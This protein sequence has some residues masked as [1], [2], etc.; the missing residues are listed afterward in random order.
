M[1][2]VEAKKWAEKK[3]F[4]DLGIKCRVTFKVVGAHGDLAIQAR[5]YWRKKA[6]Y[7]GSLFVSPVHQENV[8]VLL[9]MYVRHLEYFELVLLD[10]VRKLIN[11]ESLEEQEG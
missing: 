8:N 10:E 7:S 4:Q 3:F 9:N 6:I 2:E 5:A 1:L 11:A